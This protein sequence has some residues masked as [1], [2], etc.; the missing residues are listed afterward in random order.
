MKTP[1]LDFVEK[2]GE[3]QFS[4]FHMPGHKGKG[5]LGCERW[6]IT[7]ICGADE[8]YSPSGIILESENNASRLFST[9]HTFYSTEGSTLAIKAMLAIAK[10]NSESKVIF[11]GRNAHKSFLHACALL[12][13][14]I[15][16]LYGEREEHLCSSSVDYETVNRAFLKEKKPMGVYITTPDYLGNIT[17]ISKIAEL[18]QENDTPLLVD[19]AHGAYLNFLPENIHPI[20]LGATMCAD[21]A[22]KTL[23][24]LTGAS[25]LHISKKAGEKYLETAREYLSLFASTSPSYLTLASLDSLNQY[26]DKEYR[27]DLN[28]CIEN[29]EKCKLEIT[30][31]G[32]SVEKTEP[33]KI[34]INANSA[35]YYGYEL[36]QIL[37]E[38]KIEVEYADK[39][40]TVL[41]CS[42]GN[43]KSD[44]DRLAF[45]ISEIK[46]K[47]E[48]CLDFP[49][50]PRGDFAM[51]VKDALFADKENLSVDFAV[52]RI[53]AS[54]SVSCPP[55]IPIA[56]AGELITER[57]VEALKF[58]GITR[59][60]VVKKR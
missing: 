39:K 59:I 35:G 37:R 7:E 17:D 16:W 20:K 53:M 50:T 60:D 28:K 54:V 4:R 31:C 44:F 18:C 11:A 25:Y 49:K 13:I 29:V 15:V 3:K 38:E 30:K 9:A 47:K 43:E 32:F 55:A 8:L 34:T 58:Y 19:N 33:L 5:R 12:D 26:L 6:D 48:L 57:T 36:A 42:P 21:S 1:I 41:M 27:E 40:Y 23:P 45:S 14:E 22:H 56:V 46:I 2:Y 51:S 24:A 52:G 10:A